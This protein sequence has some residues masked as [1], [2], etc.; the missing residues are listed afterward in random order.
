MLVSTISGTDDGLSGIR[1]N[2]RSGSWWIQGIKMG[3]GL[4]PQEKYHRG[5]VYAV[6]M[7][8]AM[9]G[10]KGCWWSSLVGI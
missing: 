1:R 8:E 10:R 4:P 5:P 6:T 7:V 9:D 3:P 2:H